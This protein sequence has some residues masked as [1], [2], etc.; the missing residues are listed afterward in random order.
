MTEA[1]W[2]DADDPAK[3]LKALLATKPG[4]RKLRLFAC[5]CVR[6]VRHRLPK[7]LAEKVVGLAERF[8]DGEATGREMSQAWSAWGGVPPLLR[9]QSRKS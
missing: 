8:A 9:Y 5:A 2:P 3:M 4:D 7:G 6:L 1:D